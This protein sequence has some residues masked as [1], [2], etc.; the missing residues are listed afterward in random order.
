MLPLVRGDRALQNW[1]KVDS[2]CSISA[3]HQSE[4]QGCDDYRQF[5]ELS[6]NASDYL[7]VVFTV[8]VNQN[9]YPSHTPSKVTVTV[10]FRSK[11]IKATHIHICN[12]GN[13]SKR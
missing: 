2:L 4:N 1:A 6:F 8:I 5:Y 3:S 13:L 9:N 10:F 7:T 11:Y 12:L